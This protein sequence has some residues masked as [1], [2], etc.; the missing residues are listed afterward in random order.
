M[1][2]GSASPD[3]GLMVRSW[4]YDDHCQLMKRPFGRMP[5]LWQVDQ[6][7]ADCV[8]PNIDQT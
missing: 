3:E 8:A 5:M 6:L 1:L 4:E 7:E 2:R